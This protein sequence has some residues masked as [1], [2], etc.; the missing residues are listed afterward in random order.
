MAKTPTVK[1]RVLNMAEDFCPKDI[2]NH[3]GT[4]DSY[5]KRIIANTSLNDFKPPLTLENYGRALYNGITLKKDLA[6]YFG[7]TRMTINRF[8][9]QHKTIIKR[10]KQLKSSNYSLVDIKKQLSE[11][12]EV[13][14]IFEPD[15][16]ATRLLKQAL[17]KIAKCY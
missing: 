2:A 12:I 4:S 6:V 7:V 10:Y 17:S 13:V 3:I 11:I 9:N 14:S 16:N 15:C 5:V 8:E 1:E